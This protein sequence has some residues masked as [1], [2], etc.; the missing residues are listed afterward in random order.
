MER[1]GETQERSEELAWRA[2]TRTEN[3]IP[4]SLRLFDVRNNFIYHGRLSSAN[5]STDDELANQDLDMI[6]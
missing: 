5:H 2:G 3:L 4:W 1:T 6:T